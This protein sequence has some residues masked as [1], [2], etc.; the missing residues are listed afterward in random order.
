MPDVKQSVFQVKFT[1]KREKYKS[2]VVCGYVLAADRPEAVKLATETL[3][4]TMKEMKGESQIKLLS[5][6][7]L[8]T[9]FFLIAEKQV[10]TESK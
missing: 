5:A 7:S 2:F 10:N 6:S 4:E 3:A 8:Q 9:D 1:V